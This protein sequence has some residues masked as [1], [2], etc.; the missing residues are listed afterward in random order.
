MNIFVWSPLLVLLSL[1]LAVRGRRPSA[2]PEPEPEPELNGHPESMTAV[3]PPGDEEYLAWLADHSWPNDDYLDLERLWRAE[4][5]PITV[6]HDGPV[7]PG[8]ERAGD[9]VW[10]CPNCGLLVHSTC[11]HGMRRRKIS[12]PYR[13]RDMDT[14]SVVAEWVCRRCASIV[15]L[16]VDRGDEETGHGLHQ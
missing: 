9:D 11:G 16:D 1:T 12:K 3:L 7:C 2:A 15:G 10:P 6:D 5:E 8:C 14:E 4:L 13:T